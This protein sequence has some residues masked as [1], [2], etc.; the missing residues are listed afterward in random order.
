VGLGGSPKFAKGTLCLLDRGRA[1]GV[2]STL[3]FE[4][5]SPLRLWC[6][7]AGEDEPSAAI[8]LPLFA[9]ALEGYGAIARPASLLTDEEASAVVDGLATICLERSARFLADGLRESYF[10]FDPGRSPGRGEHNL[11]RAR[12]Q[13]ALYRSVEEQRGAL[14]SA[15]RAALLGA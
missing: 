2:A 4:A 10:G 13:L 11:V 7:S 15:A 5:P 14:D 12:G 8:E 1:C 9:A 3:G 6:N